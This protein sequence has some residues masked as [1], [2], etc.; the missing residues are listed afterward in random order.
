MLVEE[1]IIAPLSLDRE[2]REYPVSARDLPEYWGRWFVPVGG[3]YMKETNL[4][5]FF[6]LGKSF[7]GMNLVEFTRP[8]LTNPVK[9]LDA[10]KLLNAPDLWL[11]DFLTQTE[12]MEMPDS[13]AAAR[14]LLATI[15][16]WFMDLVAAL[17]HKNPHN[18]VVKDETISRFNAELKTFE[19]A[20]NRDCKYLYVFTVTPKGDRSTQILLTNPEKKFPTNLVKAMPQRTIDDLQEAGKC[21]VFDRPTASAFHICRA[22]EGLMRAYYKKLTG[23]DWP[24]PPPPKI[25]PDWGVLVAQ[26]AVNGAPK[27]ITGRLEEIRE[28]RNSFAHP[29]VTVSLEDGP[30]VYDLCTNIMH[31]IAK[32]MI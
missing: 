25:R 14:T 28:D 31:L 21:L 22:T 16:G 3:G 26:L 12:D 11:K 13:R 7:M 9:L 27:Q 29:D 24:P 5:I 8:D 6:H 4:A 23:H 17:D 20:F 10:V 30:L 18:A 1:E 32:E 15:H 2:H 19:E